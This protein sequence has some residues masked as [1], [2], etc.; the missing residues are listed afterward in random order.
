MQQRAS[1]R[2][3]DPVRGARVA[4]AHRKQTTAGS[5]LGILAPGRMGLECDLSSQLS[6]LCAGIHLL[7]ARPAHTQQA[8][9]IRSGGGGILFLAEARAHSLITNGL[10]N[11]AHNGAPMSGAGICRLKDTPPRE[12]YIKMILRPLAVKLS[13]RALDHCVARIHI[14]WKIVTQERGLMAFAQINWTANRVEKE[15]LE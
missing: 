1:E 9:C 3:S 15:R 2:Q 4:S 5:P 7:R 6:L 14:S 12:R 10:F 11:C 13:P 8:H